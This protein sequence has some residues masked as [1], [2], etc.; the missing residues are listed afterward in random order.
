[1]RPIDRVGAG[2][3]FALICT[4]TIHCCHLNFHNNW[5]FFLILKTKMSLSSKMRL[6][7][8]YCRFFF[9]T[10]TQKFVLKFKVLAILNMFTQFN[11]M[12]VYPFY[13]WHFLLLQICEILICVVFLHL[14]AGTEEIPKKSV[15]NRVASQLQK[16]LRE[17]GIAFLVNHGISE[18]KVISNAPNKRTPA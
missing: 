2:V 7:S 3:V 16:A 12:N 13:Y 8:C 1:M 17:K 6:F 5:L 10:D 11:K 15:V 18:E 9:V 4:Q 14:F